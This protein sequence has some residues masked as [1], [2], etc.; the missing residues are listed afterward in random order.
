MSSKRKNQP[1]KRRIEHLYGTTAGD[2][3][4][5]S[6]SVDP[7][8]GEF[9]FNQPMENAYSQVSYDRPKGPK[10]L[11]RI[12]QSAVSMSFDAK[13]ALSKHYDHTIAVDTNTRLIEGH[14]VSV[15]AVVSFKEAPPPE[16]ADAYWKLD[17]PFCWEFI[18]LKTDKKENLGWVAA[19]EELLYR[20]IIKQGERVGMVVDSDLGNIPAINAR[21]VPV[22][23]ATYLPVGVQL[24]YGSADTGSEN[25]VNRVLQ[26]A[27]SAANQVL[28]VIQNGDVE[29]NKCDQ[30]TKWYSGYRII[31]ADVVQTGDIKF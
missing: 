21:Q 12:P 4:S 18:D 5:L 14:E 7:S 6:I 17:I 8:T 29:F 15:T 26:A 9:K 25:V 27:D 30:P 24:I 20:G 2:V 23:D 31:N 22:F 10:V 13:D 28:D 19:L 16:G 3:T 11:T 1:T